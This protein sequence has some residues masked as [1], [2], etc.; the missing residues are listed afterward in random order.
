MTRNFNITDAAVI[1]LA[2][3]MTDAE[4]EEE[5]RISDAGSSEPVDEKNQQVVDH[6]LKQEAARRGMTVM[7]LLDTLE[8][9]ARM[10]A[11]NDPLYY[12]KLAAILRLERALH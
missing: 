9:E 8:I 7:Q 1:E 11:E 5:F 6:V 4:V 2:A 10:Q 3:T 12:K